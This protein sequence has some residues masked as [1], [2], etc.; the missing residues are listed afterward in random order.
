MTVEHA[1]RCLHRASGRVVAGALLA[2]A[3]SVGA[4]SGAT[5]SLSERARLVAVYD[6]IL[7]ARFERARDRLGTTCPPAPQAACEALEAVASWWQIVLDPDSRQYDAGLQAS[8]A[9]A[10]AT[11]TAWIERE[12]MG[13]ELWFYLA[14]A[15]AP[16]VQ[17]RILRGQRL[18]AARE[19]SRI[20]AALE[21]A[22]ALDPTLHDAKF[23]I[24]LYRYYADVV[25]APA[26]IVRWLLWLPGGDKVRGLRDMLDARERGALLKG[27]ADF[28]LHWLYLW[29]ERQPARALELLGGLAR[30]YPSNP[31]FAQ[32][33]A[34]VQAEYGGDHPAS[35]ATWTALLDRASRGQLSA[36][37]LAEARAQ[38][39]L[40]AA[41]DAMFETDRAIPH[42]EAVV[43]SNSPEPHGAVTEA[44]LR[45]GAAYNRLGDRPRAQ[46]AYERAIATAPPDAAVTVKARARAAI[47]RPPA[48]QAADAYRLSLD[49][50]RALERGD[51]A[52]AATRLARARALAPTDVVIDY[53]A[54]RVH[55]AR[56]D[57]ARARQ[58]LERILHS[59]APA[60]VRASAHADYAM[61][62]EREDDTTRAIEHY[63]YARAVVGGAHDAREAARVAL[64]RLAP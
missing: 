18:A 36:S 14:G 51:V 58:E 60:I 11:A 23:G 57:R 20:K 17:W 34:E 15:H 25:P 8:A 3:A 33:I 19:G 47:N 22:L 53:R 6:E 43:Q 32:R 63:R 2:T 35:A 26:K 49:G 13:A 12:P 16:L 29:Y 1:V 54:A 48:A 59:N 5:D 24:G 38:L 62:L 55:L 44:H 41:L 56:G 52:A 50:L 40:G 37:R 7:S 31:V 27:E 4:A 46:A 64:A 21:R 42:F 9:R 45:L 10:I 39:G 61:L 30:R 28:Q